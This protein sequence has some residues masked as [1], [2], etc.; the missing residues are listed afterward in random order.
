[1]IDAV[2]LLAVLLV[3]SNVFWAWQ[4]HLLLNK[5]MSGTFFQYQ[6]AKKIQKEPKQEF[7]DLENPEFYDEHLESVKEILT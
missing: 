3:L 1:M 2:S 7:Q 5:A 6:E 4:C